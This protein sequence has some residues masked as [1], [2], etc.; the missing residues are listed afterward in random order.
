M[1]VAVGVGTP[2]VPRLLGVVDKGCHCGY[3]SL[4]AVLECA[5]QCCFE[6]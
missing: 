6:G 3:M 2:V 5:Q 1:A 4:T